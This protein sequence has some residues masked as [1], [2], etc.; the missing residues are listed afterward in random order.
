ML[1]KLLIGLTALLMS[2]GTTK[3]V[4]ATPIPCR[5]SAFPTTPKEFPVDCVELECMVEWFDD[6]TRF[7]R[8]VKRWRDDVRSCKAIKEDKISRFDNPTEYGLQPMAARIMGS[9]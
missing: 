9:F 4:P 8:Q 5:I 1:K 7:M 2:C 6:Q 3:Y